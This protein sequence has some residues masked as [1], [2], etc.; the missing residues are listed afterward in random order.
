MIPY[1][2]PVEG[3]SHVGAIGYNIDDSHLFV[4]YRHKENTVIYC[5]Q[6]VTA[7]DFL[8][9]L[10]AESKGKWIHACIKSHPELFPFALVL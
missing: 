4:E 5:Y 8:G 10:E 1:M 7:T 2:I 9:L 3:S 6:N